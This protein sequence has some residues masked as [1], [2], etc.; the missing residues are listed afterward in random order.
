M[1]ILDPALLFGFLPITLL[2]FALLGR[3]AGRTGALA[4]L[5]AASIVFCIPFGLPGLALL[6]GSTLINI[7]AAATVSGAQRPAAKQLALFGSLALNFGLLLVFKYNNLLGNAGLTATLAGLVPVTLSFLTFQRSVYVVDANRGGVEFA[8]LRREPA[9]MQWLAPAAFLSFFANLVIGPIAYFSEVGPQL[10]S[11]RFGKLRV[12]D[13]QV[14]VTLITIGL[15]KKLLLADPLGGYVV[16]NVFGNM[17]SPHGAVPLEVVLA[18]F[19]Y[20]FQ[21]YFDFSG[22]S[23]IALGIARLF[24]IRLPINFNSPLRSSSIADFYRRWHITLTRVI[25]KFLF[26]PLGLFGTRFAAR[27]RLRGWAMRACSAWI[28][29]LINFEVIGLWHGARGTYALFGLYHGLWYV[30]DSEV[31]RTRRW[32]QYVAR[33]SEQRRY[34]LGRAITLLP[35]VLSFALFRSNSVAAFGNLVRCLAADWRNG[36]LLPGN[37]LDNNYLPLA[38]LGAAVAVA[39]LMPNAY[40]FM[41][42]YRPGIITYKVPSNTPPPLRFV[43]RPTWYWA[44]LALVAGVFAV[45]LLNSSL[46]FVYGGF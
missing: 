7:A 3:V 9:Y 24:G 37:R 11:P 21:L 41:C 14:G 12:R 22:Y 46:P 29:F 18:M 16:D 25:A 30:L 15:A 28:P 27:R 6:L 19:G 39:W 38:Y 43:W 17:A 20:F 32:K 35:L 36:Y 33:T 23:D 8:R 10:L 44:V 34:W 31:R 40:E 26:T 42:R 45:Q 1:N 4:A 13:I 5:F 2:A